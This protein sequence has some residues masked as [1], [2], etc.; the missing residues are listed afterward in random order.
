MYTYIL[1]IIKNLKSSRFCSF[2]PIKDTIL[3][4]DKVNVCVKYLNQS[5]YL[6]PYIFFPTWLNQDFHLR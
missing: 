5:K 6:I 4:V 2:M 1:D 3:P